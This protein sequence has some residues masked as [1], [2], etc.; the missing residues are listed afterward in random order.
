LLVLQTFFDKTH[1][2]L[3]L[4]I[5][6][7]KMNRKLVVIRDILTE[8]GLHANIVDHV[9]MPLIKATEQRLKALAKKLKHSKVMILYP[10][11]SGNAVV[12]WEPRRNNRDDLRTTLMLT[13]D[14][15]TGA[16]NQGQWLRGKK[17]VTS[18]CDLSPDGK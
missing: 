12:I 4:V 16:I 10:S 3:W 1:H 13:Y 6:K 8:L 5:I 2:R 15:K 18:K 14:T 7:I 17:I 11:Q 9:L